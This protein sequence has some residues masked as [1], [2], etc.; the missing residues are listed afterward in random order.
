MSATAFGR[1]LDVDSALHRRDP[2][3]KLALV[4][5]ISAVVTGVFDPWTP[6]ILY[7]LA[8]PAVVL[9]GRIPLGTMARAHL[10]FAL[11]GLSL[12]TVNALT[13]PGPVV[14]VLGPLD[15][16]VPGLEIGISLAV[17][18]LLIGTLSLG[19]VL[20]T[21]GARLMTSLHQ[22]VRLSGA[23]A[24]A[25]L[26]GYRLLEQLPQ[27]WQTIRQAQAMRRP[28]SSGGGSPRHRSRR[29]RPR[30]TERPMPLPRSPR[31]LARASFTLLVTTLRRGERMSIALETRGLGAGRR[32]IHDPARL[33]P[34]DAVLS[35][36]AL[37]TVTAVLLATW[38]C[39]LLA[40]WG[41]LGVF[42]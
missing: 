2:A 15:V 23:F 35:A 24:Y 20:T 28:R 12:F 41:A 21:D 8:V 26:A 33:T 14:W 11:F 3:V 42:G 9:A 10:P 19:F 29:V 31:A 37:A 4:L 30:R 17:R 25:V 5:V 36:V 27:Q 13:R 1:P 40:G 38:R 22:H 6:T 34:G 18:T 16:S 39:G 32:T 7:L